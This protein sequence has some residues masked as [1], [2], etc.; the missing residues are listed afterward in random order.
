MA[1]RPFLSTARPP[2]ENVAMSPL[3]TTITGGN[4]P[5][6]TCPRS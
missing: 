2:G 4:L 3:A 1:A 6:N 5:H